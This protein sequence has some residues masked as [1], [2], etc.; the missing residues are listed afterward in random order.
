M[1]QNIWEKSKV[2][3]NQPNSKNNNKKTPSL[4][5]FKY[6]GYKTKISICLLNF[7]FPEDISVSSRQ[8]SKCAYKNK[9]L[10]VC[11]EELAYS[12][13]GSCSRH[14]NST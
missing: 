10:I 13:L 3:K 1:S 5:I 12:P 14:M 9:Q 11:K 4:S 2:K 7:K 8:N 6:L